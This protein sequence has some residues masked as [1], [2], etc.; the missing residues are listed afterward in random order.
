MAIPLTSWKEIARYLGKGVRTAQRWERDLALPVRRPS[1]RRK[2]VVFALAEEMDG[3]LHHQQQRDNL[4][5]ELERLRIALAELT[6]ENQA[7]RTQLSLFSRRQK[8]R[9]TES[10]R[11]PST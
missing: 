11:S 7:L 4:K 1:G 5:E 3:W 9:R 2:G 10:V 8:T 6:A